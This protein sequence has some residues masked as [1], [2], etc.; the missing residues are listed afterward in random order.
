MIA[1]LTA[2]FAAGS[3]TASGQAATPKP[4]T[5]QVSC[6][7]IG[8][9]RKAFHAN[10]W[11]APFRF[12]KKGVAVSMDA[13]ARASKAVAQKDRDF[14]ATTMRG[15]P[16]SSGLEVCLDAIKHLRNGGHAS[17]VPG[18]VSIADTFDVGKLTCARN[19]S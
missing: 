11:S 7:P 5:K 8:R 12:K 15:H 19:V 1:D 10:T 2:V 3:A 16:R 14:V 6:R 18:A 17:A 13:P 4:Q 9:V